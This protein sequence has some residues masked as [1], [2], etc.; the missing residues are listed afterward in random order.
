M[1]DRELRISSSEKGVNIVKVAALSFAIVSWIATAQ[2]METYVF[3]QAWQALLVSFGIQGILFVFN[4]KL[5]EY[6]EAIGKW[7]PLQDRVHRKWCWGAR[8]GKDKASFKWNGMQR[9]IAVFYVMVM[10]SSSIFSFVYICNT[11]VYA[12]HSGYV[13]A[14]VVLDNS[15]RAVLDETRKYIVE[16]LS[17]TQVLASIR[18]SELQIEMHQIEDSGHEKT[19]EDLQREAVAAQRALTDAETV[20]Q[21]KQIALTHA[22]EV[23]EAAME[24]RYWASEEYLQAMEAYETA[25]DEWLEA[26][27]VV[28]E[29]R[30]ILD[31]IQIDINNYVPS[32]RAV[33]NNLLVEILQMGQDM[34]KSNEAESMQTIVLTSES[35]AE[36]P[37]EQE[38]ESTT[39]Q[40]VMQVAPSTIEQTVSQDGLS[41]N[42]RLLYDMVI[43]VGESGSVP[44][45]YST[46]VEKTQ[47]LN[48]VIEQCI[49]LRELEALEIFDGTYVSAPVIPDPKNETEFDAQKA[50]WEEYWRQRYL[51]LESVIKSLPAY[52][53]ADSVQL[54]EAGIDTER[55]EQFNA[56]D[57]VD[58]M[59]DA[60]RRE[61][62]DINVVE[63][64]VFLL[65]GKHPFIAWFSLGL[66]LFLDVSA[67]LAGLFIHATSKKNSNIPSCEM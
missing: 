6:F 26:N 12:R 65:F 23:L 5:P 40:D 37:N 51:E 60:V 67:L 17:A 64:A 43:E 38:A 15:Y 55:L 18:L 57:L 53:G 62:S 30:E 16:D 47:Q 2:G 35:V 20:L 34:V 9:I 11:A 29:K 25:Y 61:L 1:N 59:N 21:S 28:A 27:T 49:H 33:I 39:E 4:L 58:S 8:K 44:E 10:L 13:D 3:D 66:A 54:A 24:V 31:N 46:I 14:N 19:K 7:T 22:D 50:L 63:K 42:L 56:S 48:I 41:E 36:L 45:N 52:S 32:Q